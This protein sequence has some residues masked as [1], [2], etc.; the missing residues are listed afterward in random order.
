LLLL[1][2]LLLVLLLLPTPALRRFVEA[3][4]SSLVLASVTHPVHPHTSLTSFLIT[5]EK[6]SLMKRA[7]DEAENEV[8]QYREQRQQ[9]FTNNVQMVCVGAGV[10]SEGRRGSAAVGL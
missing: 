9:E 2:C 3:H 6:T 4:P 5:P 7:R 10:G 8:K 1:Y